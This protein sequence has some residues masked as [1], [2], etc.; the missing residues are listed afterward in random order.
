SRTAAA[1]SAS[2]FSRQMSM[3]EAYIEGYSYRE[4]AIRYDTP[5]NTVR[6]WLR[7]SLIALRKCLEE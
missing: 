7:R 6:T 3:R 1:F 2:S 4:L 5:I